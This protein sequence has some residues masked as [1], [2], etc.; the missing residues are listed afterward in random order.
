MDALEGDDEGVRQLEQDALD[1]APEDVGGQHP[2]LAPGSTSA[3]AT[4]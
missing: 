3:R 2:P 1:L 4:W